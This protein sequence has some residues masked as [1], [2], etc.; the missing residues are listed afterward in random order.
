METKQLIEKFAQSDNIQSLISDTSDKEN[1]IFHLNGLLASS[2]NFYFLAFLKKKTS[3]NL[4]VLSDREEAAYFQNDLANISEKEDFLFF[5]SSFKRSVQYNKIDSASIIQRTEVF[6][7]ITSSTRKITIVTYTEALIEKVIT[8]DELDE[9]TLQLSV[10][11]ELSIDF[12]S[13]ML[14]EYNFQLVDFVYEPGQYSVRGSIVDIFSFS[15]DN[16]FRIDFFGDEVESIR[17]FDIV[18]QLSKAKFENIA[19]IPDIQNKN[20]SEKRISLFKFL[21]KGTIIWTKNAKYTKNKLNSIYE[22]VIEKNQKLLENKEEIDEEIKI[23]KI[24]NLINGNVFQTEIQKFK[25]IEFGHEKLFDS[26]LFYQFNTSLQPTFSKNFNLLAHDLLEKQ[27]NF[28]KLFIFSENV[29]QIDR[30]K[31]V[32]DSEEINST[33]DFEPVINSIYSGF[34]DRDLKICCYTDHQIFERY[35]KFK[36]KNTSIAK[37][38]EVL[39]LSELQDLQPGDYVVHSDHGIG[40]FGGLQT[41]D[42]NDK[43]QEVIRLIYRDND[44]LLVSIHSL[45]RISKYR[46][47]DSE[48]PKMYKLGSG[49]WQKLKARTK[50]KVKDIAKELI[51]L[52][53][54]RRHE[55]GFAFAEDSY[56]QQALEASFLYEDTPDQMQANI[57]VKADMENEKPMDRLV[58][59]DVGFGK[60]EIAIRA[61][62]KAVA[63][64]KQVAILVPTTILALQHY[65]T[66]SKRLKEFPATVDYI[67]RLR[68]TKQVN[69]TL[70]DLQEGKIDILI[71]THKII[72]K[73][74][75][76]KDLGLLIV[77]EEQKFGVSM[78]EKLKEMKLNVD[79]LTLTATP[80]PRTLQFS[81]MGARDLSIIKTPPP[82]R[83]PIL[84]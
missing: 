41:M 82:N 10:G 54:M 16:P 44:I 36:V 50:A 68:T 35:Y 45:H 81:L 22:A 65:K 63:D 40:R 66:F 34:Y 12:I 58:C 69:Q 25:I 52:Y 18:S 8:K 67:S 76:F 20:A 43:R 5:P 51:A 72:G 84:T 80:I 48:A 73:N 29:K 32:L 77:D 27:E 4:I 39:T 64:N 49:A 74:V 30:L 59:G 79:T 42:E 83:H 33:I 19:I 37:G 17:T 61:A 62:F 55:K 9:N 53:A 6:N 11:E 56:L 31:A 28:F 2:A 60:T 75:K 7:K 21:P 71:G 46:G 13:E 38:K 1:K 70:K 23:T 47:K 14:V 78:K 57:D 3:T 26:K 15:N 24:E